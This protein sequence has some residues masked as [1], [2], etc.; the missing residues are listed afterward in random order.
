MALPPYIGRVSNAI[1]AVASISSQALA[2][3]LGS[4]RVRV[5]FAGQVAEDAA[6]TAGAQ[7][8][9]NLLARLYPTIEFTGP[10][11]TVD[12]AVHL[13]ERI[14]P[15]IDIVNGPGPD[16]ERVAAIHYGSV[17]PSEFSVSVAAAGWAAYV[18]EQ[19]ATDQL[20]N[21]FSALAAGCLGAAE[22]FREVFT[23]NLG[24]RSRRHS[25]RG[26]LD[27]V[28]LGTAGGTPSIDISGVNLGSVH[29]AG[30]GA[31]G[32]AAVLALAE[33][34][35][36]GTLTIVDP[37]KIDLSNLQRYVLATVEDVGTVKVDLAVRT[38]RTRSWDAIGVESA[39]GQDDRSWPGQ[40]VVLVALDTARDRL[41][42]AA[43]VHARVYN[44]YT[45]PADIGWSRHERFGDEP[46][47]ACLYYP[48]HV[49]PSEDEVVA[50]AL[51]QPRLRVL[52]YFATNTP[53]GAPLPFV[54]PV[55]DLPV[56][57]DASRWTTTSL[58]DDLIS[59]GV[60]SFA[61]APAWA[62]R[63]IGQ[64]YTEGICG[65]GVVATGINLEDR[66]VMPLA[67]QS[68][69][70]GVMLALQPVVA[71]VP[72]LTICRPAGVEG[73]LDLNRGLP[74]IAARARQRTPG[75]ICFD[76]V[77]QAARR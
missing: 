47:L 45:Q 13:A 43:G 3:L 1:G 57:T 25:A 60:I 55:A 64:L 36:T 12:A 54:N 15:N 77:F 4:V 39:W 9:T 49:Q 48:Q 18:N 33:S 14:N 63:T 58:L 22:I 69:L 42:V 38:L 73:R 32:E 37:E 71:A 21:P 7:L 41:G 31:I 24:E 11:S 16:D 44:A 29:L 51:R 28:T 5:D 23:A 6:A 61:D 53:V 76:P 10:S 27:L 19:P 8:L 59:T 66:A 70:A 17:D 20:P 72:D 46:C 62:G 65:G 68:A 35:T 75:C 74:Q 30:A 50:S 56:P 2:E 26:S 67:H 52:S 40:Q 34:G